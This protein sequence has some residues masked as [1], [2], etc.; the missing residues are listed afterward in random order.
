MTKEYEIQLLNLLNEIRQDEYYKDR[1]KY[2]AE[3]YSDYL[4]QM[5]DIK[6]LQGELDKKLKQIEQMYDK[7]LTLAIRGQSINKGAER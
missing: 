7:I 6:F 4:E 2:L 1:Y 3:L 5:N